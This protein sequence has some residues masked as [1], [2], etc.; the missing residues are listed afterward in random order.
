MSAIDPTPLLQSISHL[1]RQIETHATDEGEVEPIIYEKIAKAISFQLKAVQDIDMFNH[2][3]N[4]NEALTKNL[5][6]ENL[7]APSADERE[8]FIER[9]THLYNRINGAAEIHSPDSGDVNGGYS[10]SNP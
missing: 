10:S 6:Y 7:S 8:R 4:E 1:L 2:H 3:R 9:L 5:N